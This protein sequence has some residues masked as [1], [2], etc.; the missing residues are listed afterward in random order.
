MDFNRHTAVRISVRP[1]VALSLYP[2]LPPSL[3]DTSPLPGEPPLAEM[4]E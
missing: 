2:R 3:P 1:R 4:N